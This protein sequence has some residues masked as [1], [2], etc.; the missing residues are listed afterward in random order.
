M[1][2]DED[3]QVA[4][5]KKVKLRLE[6]ELANEQSAVVQLKEQLE[7]SR[8]AHRNDLFRVRPA[9]PWCERG[10]ACSDVRPLFVAATR[11]GSARGGRREGA[12]EEDRGSSVCS[13]AAE[14]G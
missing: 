4:G 8:T 1:W 5:L 2:E 6:S 12:Q 13:R 7:E 11:G 14:R 10:R 3:P 9:F